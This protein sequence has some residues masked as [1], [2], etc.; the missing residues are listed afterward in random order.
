LWY[1]RLEKGVFRLPSAEAGSVEVE[2]AELML[3]LEGIELAGSRRLCA[4]L[5]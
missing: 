3:L 2:A 4:I 1:K 5:S